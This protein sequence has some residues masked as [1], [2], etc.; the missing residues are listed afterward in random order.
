M[1]QYDS[2]MRDLFLR[3]PWPGVITWALIYI[4]DFSLTTIGARL[5]RRNASGKIVFEGSFEL[6]PLFER[7]I[8]SGKFV[9]PRFLL[10]LVLSS[11]MFAIYWA[12]TVPDSSAIYIFVLGA[13]ICMELAIHVR[14]LGNLFLFRLNSASCLSGRIEYPRP[15]ILRMSSVQI[16][17]F[18]ILF[19]VVF[20]FTESWFVCG[21]M[22]SC[23]GLS[24][25][26]WILARRA[27]AKR[28]KTEQ[29]LAQ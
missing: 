29:A 24:G 10:F 6:N 23:L 20:T 18:A 7:D 1:Q 9:S 11:T 12:L 14:H 19:A 2:R 21:G 3:S 5:Y 26:H 13:A 17:G 4:S 15:L 16:L 22:V 28:P 25:K 27:A 8:D